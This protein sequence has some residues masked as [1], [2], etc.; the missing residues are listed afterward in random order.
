ML[1]FDAAGLRGT[2]AEWEL[3][4]VSHCELMKFRLMIR[5]K[6]AQLPHT[7]VV[8]LIVYNVLLLCIMK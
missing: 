1:C 5:E 8:L 4:T 6:M 7:N 3:G 2:Q